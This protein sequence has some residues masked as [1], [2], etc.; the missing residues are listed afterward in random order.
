MQLAGA[1]SRSLRGNA[2]SSCRVNQPHERQFPRD[3]VCG[4]TDAPGTI[5]ASAAR[6]IGNC[7]VLIFRI[8]AYDRGSSFFGGPMPFVL[9]SHSFRFIPPVA[10]AALALSASPSAHAHIVLMNPPSWVV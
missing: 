3:T 1:E 8:R 4:V 2:S 6:R 5:C 7:A 9:N 10:L